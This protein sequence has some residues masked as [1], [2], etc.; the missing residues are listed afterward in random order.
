MGNIVRK[1]MDVRGT[2]GAGIFC[3]WASV[4]VDF[5]HV[6]KIILFPEKCWRF[7]HTP[8]LITSCIALCCCGTY[9]G[10][11]YLRHI[12]RGKK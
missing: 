10:G 9:L 7:L 4:F 11:L 1:Y 3:G 5:D 12:L 6:L 2:L 8:I